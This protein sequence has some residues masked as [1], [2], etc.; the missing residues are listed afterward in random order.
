MLLDVHL[1]TGP[2]GEVVR[3]FEII[4]EKWP[5][6]EIPFDKIMKVAEAYHDIGEYERS[7]LVFRA[8]VESSF[9]NE[10]AVAGFLEAQGR[11]PAERRRDEPA[12]GGVSAGAVCGRDDVRA[13]AARLC[14]GA[15]AAA[16]AKL[17]EKKINRVML[18][19]QALA[20][21]DHF[22]TLYPEI[23]RPTRRRFRWRTRCW[24]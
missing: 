20:M 12:V 4:K 5:D 21:L 19:Q 1:T 18:V 2:A 14:E 22:L 7:Y 10:N 24:S 17:R 23:R 6:L 11:I 16:D 13:G 9:L 15:E 3:Y 8:T